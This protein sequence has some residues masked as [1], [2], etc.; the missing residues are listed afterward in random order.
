MTIGIDGVRA[1]AEDGWLGQAVRIG[2]AT[3]RPDGNVGRCAVTTHDPDLGRPDIDTLKLLAETRGTMAS[4]EP[5]PFGVW[6]AVVT[7]GQVR[8]GDPVVPPTP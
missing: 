8:V 5:L 6:A 3:V 7:P 2:E 4:T 1:W